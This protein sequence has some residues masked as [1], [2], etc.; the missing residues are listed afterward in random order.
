VDPNAKV[1][2]I[3]LSKTDTAT[4]TEALNLLNIRSVHF[5]QDEQTAREL[6][7]GNYR[8]TILQDYDSA[9]DTPVAPFYAQFDRAWPGSKFIL[10]VRD[11]DTWLRSVEAHWRR[12]A[13]VRMTMKTR[14]R[15]YVDF[16]NACTY[17]CLD[18]SPDRFSHAYDLHVRNVKVY[19]AGRPD[20]LLV[21]NICGGEAWP[22][23]CGFL[24][25][26]EPTDVPFPHAN[27]TVS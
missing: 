14:V 9:T 2:G 21:L 23:L 3:G 8:L 6:K 17:G 12:L 15:E 25:V 7:S 27:R 22:E 18:F 19:F 11:Q 10:T 13:A 4:L 20:D 5:P 24:G 16:I 1:F 26:P